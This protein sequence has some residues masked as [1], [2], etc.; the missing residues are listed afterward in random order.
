[1]EKSLFPELPSLPFQFFKLCKKN[2]KPHKR[3]VG[4]Y[5][6]MKNMKA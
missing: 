4:F 2:D 1:M 3:M 5:F 6:V